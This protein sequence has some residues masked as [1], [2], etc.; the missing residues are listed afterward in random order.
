MNY[1][2]VLREKPVFTGTDPVK[3]LNQ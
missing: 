1:F 3:Y 2:P